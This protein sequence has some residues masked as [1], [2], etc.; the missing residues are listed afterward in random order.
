M[1]D[2]RDKRTGLLSAS[3]SSRLEGLRPEQ[4]LS[5]TELDREEKR[6]KLQQEQA[7][8]ASELEDLST[9]RDLKKRVAKIV[10]YFLAV[11][12]GLLFIVYFC[13]GLNSTHFISTI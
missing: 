2:P 7:R 9:D 5:D 12:T 6:L 3:W 10:F 4:Q 1:N 11:E 13:R 8:G